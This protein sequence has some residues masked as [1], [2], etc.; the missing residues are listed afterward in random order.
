MRSLRFRNEMFYA[1]KLAAAF[2]CFQ[3]APACNKQ[4]NAT[5]SA[6]ISNEYL[7]WVCAELQ[8]QIQQGIIGVQLTELQLRQPTTLVKTTQDF[9][10]YS[11]NCMTVYSASINCSLTLPYRVTVSCIHNVITVTRLMQPLYTAKE[12]LC[13]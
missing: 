8:Y 1:S 6:W 11:A 4:M 3:V 9:D 7:C 2:Y 12:H 10:V 5:T 13:F